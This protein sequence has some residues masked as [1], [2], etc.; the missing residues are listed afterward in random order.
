MKTRI[1]VLSVEHKQGR[2]KTGND[3]SIDL[4]QCVV[5]GVDLETGAEKIQIGELMLPKNH[6]KIT[7]GMYDGEFGISVGQ[8]K[9]ISGRLLQ[10]HPVSAVN[11]VMN[12]SAIPAA[13][14]KA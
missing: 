9:K 11:R 7:P 1:Q 2:S 3:Y 4:C 5:H 6:P 14:L 10:L 13:A 12:T 8:D